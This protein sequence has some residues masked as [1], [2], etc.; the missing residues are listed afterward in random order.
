MG[1]DSK[2]T[3]LE[4][5][6]PGAA[7]RESIASFHLPLMAHASECP[8]PAVRPGAL[9]SQAMNHRSNDL[10]ISFDISNSIKTGVGITS[11]IDMS[12]LRG[13]RHARL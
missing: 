13:P 5:V 1:L 10:I 7:V 11:E 9:L 6:V 12:M 8:S 2:R 3:V 4:A